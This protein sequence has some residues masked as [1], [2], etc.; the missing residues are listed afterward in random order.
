MPHKDGGNEMAE[1]ASMNGA[2]W[3]ARALAGTGMSHVFFVESVMRRTLLQLS[4]LGVKPVLAHSEKAAAYM[5]DGYARVAGRPSICMAQSVGAA[6]LAS[7]LQDAWLGRSPVIA[8]T[9]HKEPSFQ[10]RNSY[11]EIPHAPLF[12]AVTKFST[13]VLS[14]SELPRL[15]R[16]AWRAALA[17]TA[18]PTHLDFN[19]LQGDVIELGQTAEPPVLETEAR[20]IP[21][22]RPLAEERDITRIAA[23]LKGAG[24]VALVAGDGAA[25]SRAGP[26]VLALAEALGAPVATTLGARGII[27]TRHRLSA[28]VAGSYSAPPANRIVHSAELVVFIGCDTGDQ[29]TLNWTVPAYETQIV[30]IEADPLEIGRSYPNTTGIVGDPKATVARLV[31]IVGR[32]MSAPARDTDFADEAARIVAD[33]R[34][35]MA[36]LIEK[37]TTPIAVERLCAEVT[38]ALP[39][40]G[41]L[42]ADTGYSGIWTGTMI[43]LNG[44]GQTYLRAAGSLGWSFPASL[45]A[46]CAAGDRKVVCFTGDGGFYYHLAELESARRAGI[47]VTLV[48]NNNSGFGQNLTG[49]HRIAGNRPGR[50]EELIRFGPTDFTAVARS[51]G[52]SG[53][54]VERPGE[55]APALREALA[56]DE[57]FVVD[58]VTD[59]EPRAPAPWAP[60]A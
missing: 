14:T 22:H 37:N 2:E 54:R 24:R 13:P 11:Q 3:L 35:S 45:G 44:A 27:P 29:V 57:T 4:D 5:A 58:V 36:P 23:L 52:L 55:I 25:T 19:G 49:V 59:L 6:N 8:L 53:I 21:V 1:A 15:L 28:G 32:S 50:G 60:P 42:V 16:H 38:R 56:A 41:I 43:E 26:E 34:D 10:H 20:A 33:W 17:D 40:D 31:E 9:G 39:A 7:G 12:S 48:V 46:K 30:Q 51:F 18:R 47:A